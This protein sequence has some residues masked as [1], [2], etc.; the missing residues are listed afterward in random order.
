MSNSPV[1]LI[2]ILVRETLTPENNFDNRR[3]LL[4]KIYLEK[5]VSNEFNRGTNSQ[6]S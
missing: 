6:S 5:G 2:K 3:K 1:A 4:Q